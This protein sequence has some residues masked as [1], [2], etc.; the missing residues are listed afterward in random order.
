MIINV[1][2][3]G[4]CAFAAGLYAGDSS[5][6]GILAFSVN[7]FFAALNGGIAATAVGR[8]FG[9]A[10]NLMTSAVFDF[11]SINKILNR[12]EQKAEFEAK[13]PPEIGW[14]MFG[15]MPYGGSCESVTLTV[16]DLPSW[17]N[18]KI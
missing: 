13:N 9:G 12:Q 1:V 7:L 3:C 8:S 17:L 14:P 4:L 2:A 16:A 5:P 15:V 6:L 18:V 11:K 10:Q